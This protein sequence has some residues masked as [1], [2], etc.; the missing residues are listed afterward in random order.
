MTDSFAELKATHEMWQLIPT[1]RRFEVADRIMDVLAKE[2]ADHGGAA[3]AATGLCLALAELLM[4][5]VPPANWEFLIDVISHRLREA[6]D[7]MKGDLKKV[8]EN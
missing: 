1:P 2:C 3:D 8:Q 7:P 4:A 6:T 5:N